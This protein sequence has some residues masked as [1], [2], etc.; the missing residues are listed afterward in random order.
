MLSLNRIIFF[1]LMPIMV[2]IALFFQIT[3]E[4]WMSYSDKSGKRYIFFIL[5]PIY[6]PGALF[7]NY[8]FDFWVSFGE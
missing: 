8:A 4:W 3:Y 7:L 2:P 1:L 6:V 5:A